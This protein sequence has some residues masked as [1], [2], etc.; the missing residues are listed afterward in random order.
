MCLWRAFEKP[1]TGSCRF[2]PIGHPRGAGHGAW[3]SL[4]RV[5]HMEKGPVTPK[6]VYSPSSEFPFGSRDG[7]CF[8]WHWDPTWVRPGKPA[9]LSRD[10]GDARRKSSS[11]PSPKSQCPSSSKGS[12]HP[13]PYLLPAFPTKW[14]NPT[15]DCSIPASQL[16]SKD[17]LRCIPEGHII[18]NL[19]PSALPKNG[20]LGEEQPR[21]GHRASIPS[22]ARDQGVLGALW[23]MAEG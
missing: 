23:T 12:S 8:S 21:T 6:P 22:L 1:K 2:F 19:L 7:T 4:G 17:L 5:S 14:T 10:R 3:G 9:F 20:S 13:L 18:P 11:Q 15:A 16:K